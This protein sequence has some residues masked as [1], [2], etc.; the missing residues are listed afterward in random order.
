MA[1]K[2]LDVTVEDFGFY[3]LLLAYFLHIAWVSLIGRRHWADVLKNK[4][5]GGMDS[6][7]FK[8]PK[9]VLSDLKA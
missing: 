2:L 6:P 5:G 8:K 1:C 4:Y 3:F 9:S 7:D